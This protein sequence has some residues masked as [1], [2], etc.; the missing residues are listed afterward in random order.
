MCKADAG[1]GA[2]A[3]G[4]DAAAAFPSGLSHHVGY[5]VDIRGPDIATQASN[6]VYVVPPQ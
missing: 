5:Y 6:N 2:K 4:I 3:G 1:A